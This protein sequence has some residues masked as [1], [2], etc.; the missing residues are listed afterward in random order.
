MP[1]DTP[2]ENIPTD[3]WEH[4]AVNWDAAMNLLNTKIRK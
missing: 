4:I 1:Q 2:L 3:L